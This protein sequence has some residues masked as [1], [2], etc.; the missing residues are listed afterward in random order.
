MFRL[1]FHYRDGLSALIH[2]E[3]S[4]AVDGLRLRPRTQLQGRKL[5]QFEGKANRLQLAPSQ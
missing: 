1:L 2:H 3:P 5:D 4:S